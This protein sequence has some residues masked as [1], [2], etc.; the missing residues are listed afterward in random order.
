MKF[1]L[2]ILSLFIV[3]MSPARAQEQIDPFSK[4]VQEYVFHWVA[5]KLR[6]KIDEKVAR[7]LVLSSL[8]VPAKKYDAFCT[9]CESKRINF[10]VSPHN[11]IWILPTSDVGVLAHEMVHYFQVQYDGETEDDSGALEDLAV[12]IQNEFKSLIALQIGKK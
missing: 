3:A 2:V 4:E 1:L 9:Y 12:D 6:V 8:D 10:Y 11:E 7:P 5:K